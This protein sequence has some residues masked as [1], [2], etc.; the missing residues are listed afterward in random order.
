MRT[1]VPISILILILVLL[2][3]STSACARRLI[4]GRV[5]D[6]V[7][8]EPIDNAAIYIAWFKSGSGP[9]GL[10]GTVKVEVAEDLSDSEGVFKIP[11]YS[12]LFK[13]YRMVVYKKGYV[14]WN[15]RKI[16]PT[17]EERKD[18]SLEDGMTIK[19]EQFKEEYSREKHAS[20]TIIWSIWSRGVF[21]EAIKEEIKI[22][23]EFWQKM[24]RNKKKENRRK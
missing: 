8:A 18:F 12:K 10:A 19:L 14:C 22:D 21:R 11:K 6:A 4:Q 23:Y 2:I 7:T 9:P 17:Y 3:L 20:F 1:R 24:R 5:V 13:W 15:S 16:F